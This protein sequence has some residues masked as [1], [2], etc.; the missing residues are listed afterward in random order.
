MIA[1][2]LILKGNDITSHLCLTKRGGTFHKM[3]GASF[4]IKLIYF[5][6]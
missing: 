2:T 3:E 5:L 4:L 1:I 6:A